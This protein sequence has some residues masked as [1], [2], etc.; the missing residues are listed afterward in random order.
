MKKKN[1]FCS[2]LLKAVTKYSSF[3]VRKKNL[4]IEQKVPDLSSQYR[5]SLFRLLFHKNNNNKKSLGGLTK[6]QNVKRRKKG[7]IKLVVTPYV[8]LLKLQYRIPSS[9]RK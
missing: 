5:Y 2:I 7:K 3:S 6:P 8:H 1:N 9:S 4:H